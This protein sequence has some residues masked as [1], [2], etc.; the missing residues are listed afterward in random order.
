[1][2]RRIAVTFGLV[3]LWALAVCAAVFA[4]A[5]WFAA[6]DARRGDFAAIER[7]LV[8]K[9][10][11][12]AAGKRI[13]AAALVLIRNGGIVAEHGF[14]AQPDRS[15][16]VVA[17]VSKAVTAWGVMRLVQEGRI[18][19]DEPVMRHLRRW[20]FPG[21][22]TY[23]DRI[24]VRHLLSHTAGIDD[25]PGY[26]GFPP[27]ARVT[28]EPGTMA[29]SSAGYAILQ[30][31][32]ED[33]TRR[34]FAESMKDA[35]LT[36]LGMTRST[37][38]GPTADTVPAFDGELKVQPPRHYAAAASVALHTTPRDLARFACAFTRE[39]AVLE[40]ETL[41]RMFAPQPGTA[42]TWGLGH[43]LYGAKVVGH[44][45]GTL[46][47]WGAMLRVNRATGNGMVLMVSGGRGALNRL[48]HDW[49]AWE[50]GRVTSDGRR[51]LVYDRARPAAI[52]M[53]VGAIA[54]VLWR[55]LSDRRRP[56]G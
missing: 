26:D 29:Y 53:L 27:R 49:V 38:A 17:S 40:R 21:S 52:A 23:R 20:R 13:G 28:R 54:I 45:G 48:A 42:G 34:P 37:F 41:R 32:V 4:E 3:V 24:S 39:N 46:P 10:R 55:A 36:P 19:L 25:G 47:A 18:G 15:Q 51:Q 16:F 8:G 6:P 1:M 7:H 30:L 44:D 33:V 9:I 12:A 11:D 14:G 35:V 31:L 50:T 5:Y 43:A 56:A 2:L 22:E